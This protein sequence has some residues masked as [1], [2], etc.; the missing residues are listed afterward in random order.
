[1]GFFITIFLDK[2][3]ISSWVLDLTAGEVSET[4][5]TERSLETSLI[6]SWNLFEKL[7]LEKIAGHVYRT[8]KE[9]LKTC[10]TQSWKFPE[11]V[12]L[13]KIASYGYGTDWECLKTDLTQLEA[14]W[15]I[16]RGI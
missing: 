1:M 7:I 4:Y 15:G 10:L 2:E 5:N 8:G 12:S 9:G 11:K 14:L 13:E 3:F 6:Q 16:G